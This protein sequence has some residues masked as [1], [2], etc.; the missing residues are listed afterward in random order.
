LNGA[1]LFGLDPT[2]TRCALAADPLSAAQSDAAD[3]H[4][5]G[6][7]GSPWLGRGPMSRR[8]MFEW[9]AS[10]STRWSPY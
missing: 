4:Q 3:M 7:L 2:A 5:E 8:E 9:L 6:A 10:P 1:A